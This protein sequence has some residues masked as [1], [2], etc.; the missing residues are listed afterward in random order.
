MKID[1]S[2]LPAQFITGID[3]IKIVENF[4]VRD[5]YDTKSDVYIHKNE[6]KNGYFVVCGGCYMDSNGV[7]KTYPLD[8]YKEN[9]FYKKRTFSS[10]E[11]AWN[12][13]VECN[14]D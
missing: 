10:L 14:L 1:L 2:N 8:E 3:K 11:K 7:F 6:N 4:E 5:E 13:F 12:T 9:E